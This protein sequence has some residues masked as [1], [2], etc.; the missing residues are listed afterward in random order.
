MLTPV[1][2]EGGPALFKWGKWFFKNDRII[3]EC[4]RI[5]CEFGRIIGECGQ[6]LILWKIIVPLTRKT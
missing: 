3:G 2:I 4:G 1:Q 5:I 6:I